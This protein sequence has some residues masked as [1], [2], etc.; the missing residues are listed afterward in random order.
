MFLERYESSFSSPT[1][2]LAMYEKIP[3]D[4]RNLKKVCKIPYPSCEYNFDPT[5]SGLLSAEIPPRSGQ[6]KIV[7][8]DPSQSQLAKK[9]YGKLVSEVL[10]ERKCHK[11]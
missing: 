9:Y 1:L 4:R 11:K 7:D 3:S 8:L 2:S 10:V 6:T 5:D